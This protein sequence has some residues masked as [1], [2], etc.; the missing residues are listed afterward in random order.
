MTE[1]N[2]PRSLK[3]LFGYA[4]NYYK[5]SNKAV[6][7]SLWFAVCSIVQKGISVITMPVFTRLMTEEQ[8]GNYS[9]FLTW[10][11]ILLIL[12]TLNVHTELFNKGLI[13][14]SEDMDGYSANQ[15]GLLIALTAFWIAVY[16]PFRSFFNKLLGLTTVL[17]LFMIFEILGTA[18]IGLWSARKRFEFDYIKIVKLTLSMAVLNPVAGIAAV[19][20]TEHKAEAR[21]ISNA[22]I[23]IIFAAVLLVI[24]ARHGKLF[25][26]IKL[27]KPVVIA[28]LPLIPHYL[29]LVLLNQSDKLMIKHFCGAED[30]AIYS[31]AHSAGLLMTII[32]N[33]INGSFVPWSYDK[34]KNHNGRGIKKVSSSLLMIVVFV[35][36]LLIWVAPEAVKLLAAPQYSEAVWCLVPI[37]MS[38]Y[39]FFAYTMFVDFEIYYGANNYIAAASITAAA[40]NILLN[41]IFIPKFGYIAAGY[42]TLFSYFATMLMHM[43]F[44]KIVLKK[45]QKRFDMF[46]LRVL[47]ALAIVLA[48]LSA[49]AML[50]YRYF[51]IRWLI[52]AAAFVIVVIKRKAILAVF[53]ELK[54]KKENLE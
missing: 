40:L 42:T 4:V 22:V 25:G 36:V 28:S 32:N 29:S 46:D 12:V 54:N 6:R 19:L 35:N 13:E 33:S 7:A 50:L 21:V 34:L 8:Y 16:L 47:F 20:M 14:H 38:V 1:N 2:K 39:F 41:Y 51:V 11:N 10:Y 45:Q 3:A 31:V 53:G 24:F 15:A 26:N 23:P 27:W 9:V 5:N 52:I 43:L 48:V 18:I 49:A 37:A 17:V 30:A 44:F